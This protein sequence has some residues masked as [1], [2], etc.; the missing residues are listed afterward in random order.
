SRSRISSPLQDS[1][2]G[3]TKID[4][5]EKLFGNRRVLTI[6]ILGGCK[7]HAKR[8]TAGCSRV[9]D[10]WDQLQAATAKRLPPRLERNSSRVLRSR[11]GRVRVTPG[12]QSHSAIALRREGFLGR[13]D[14]RGDLDELAIF[15]AG[16]LLQPAKGVL[17]VESGAFHQYP[18][19]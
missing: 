8:Q 12:I 9:W 4:R 18:L 7:P 1:R 11:R 14:H 19:G 3:L 13:N 10:P 2:T 6:S 15:F 16:Q 5:R 17:L